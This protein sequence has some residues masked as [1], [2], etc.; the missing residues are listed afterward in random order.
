MTFLSLLVGAS[1][2]AVDAGF[3]PNDMQVGQTGKIVA[4]VSIAIK[5]AVQNSVGISTACICWT[6]ISVIYILLND[7]TQLAIMM[8]NVSSQGLDLLVLIKCLA[9]FKLRIILQKDLKQYEVLMLVIL[10]MQ[11]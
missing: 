6:I 3:V 2:A 9:V 8:V 5:Y 11:S 1:R 4:P 10:C 7:T